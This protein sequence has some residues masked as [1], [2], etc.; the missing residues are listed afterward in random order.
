MKGLILLTEYDL[1]HLQKFMKKELDQNRYQHTLG[2]M[3]TAAALAMA[4]GED[5]ERA[6]VAGL[7]HDCAKCIPNKKKLK[8]C[9][10]HHIPVSGYEEHH[11]FM[12]HAKLGAW[13]AKHKYHVKDPDVLQAIL[14][15]T[16]GK[17]RM[18]RLEKIIFIADYMEPGRTKASDLPEVR[19]LAFQDL[20][21]CMYVICRDT[22]EYLQRADADVEENTKRACDYYRSLY[23][24]QGGETNEPIPENGE[25][26][27]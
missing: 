15:H 2:V 24:G 7:L 13:L 11:P 4:H 26:G 20:D 1:A 27:R 19:R 16:T 9:R 3:F 5:M 8:I 25:N 23:E 10:N 21:R 17:P 12:L 14:W 18:S 22:L 6:E